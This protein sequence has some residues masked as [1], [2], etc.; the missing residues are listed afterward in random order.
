MVHKLLFETPF[1]EW[2]LAQL[3]NRMGVAVVPAKWLGDQTVSLP[4]GW[5][6]SSEPEDPR[7]DLAA[8][9]VL[10]QPG[11][12]SKAATRGEGL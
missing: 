10:T 3:E 11:A 4:V 6:P 7:G 2:L 12:T 5:Q 1:G 8:E 9:G